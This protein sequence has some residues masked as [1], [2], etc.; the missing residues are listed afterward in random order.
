MTSPWGAVGAGLCATLLGVGL[1]R[2]AYAPLHPALVEAGWLTA[3]QAGTLTALNFAG[4]LLG[5]MLAPWLG[6]RIGVR[7]SLRGAMLTAGITL[8]LCAIRLP[9]LWFVPWRLLAGVAGGVLMV[10]AGPA[11]QAVM[12]ARL[13]GRAAGVMFLGPG[14]GMIAGALLVPALL[15][16]GPA[17]IWLALSGAALLLAALSWR[18]WPNPEV[19]APRTSFPDRPEIRRL[20]I[21]YGLTGAATMPHMVWWADYIARGLHRGTSA[22]AGYWL[23]YGIAALS[24]AAPTGLLADRIGPARALRLMMLANLTALLLALLSTAIPALIASGALAGACNVSLTVLTLTRARALADDQAPA[25]WR[26]ATVALAVG[27]MGCGFAM[28]ALYGTAGAFWPLFALGA[29][30]AGAAVVTVWR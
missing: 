30:A 26:A 25:V 14:S 13:R 9:F 7:W 3:T 27:Q 2:F 6:R 23:I 5:A 29:A 20:I 4:Y 1:Q 24:A 28:A 11:V 15:P 17:T 10:L 19:P 8:G 21:A 12:P 22:G 18:H 16:Y